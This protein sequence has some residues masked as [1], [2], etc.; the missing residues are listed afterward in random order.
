MGYIIASAFY[1]AGMMSFITGCSFVYIEIY[2]VN[3]AHFGFLVGLNVIS[4]MFASTIN[5]RYVEKLGTEVLSKY[6]IY[7][8]L[9]ASILMIVLSLFNH[10]PFG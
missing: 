6:A 8:P 9:V 4:M 10:P 2:H 1:F 7:I 5:G 3:P